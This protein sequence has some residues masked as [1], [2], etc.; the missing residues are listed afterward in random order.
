MEKT[1]DADRKRIAELKQAVREDLSSQCQR[2]AVWPAFL[3]DV[4]HYEAEQKKL[5]SDIVELQINIEVQQRQNG[6]L[7]LLI[8]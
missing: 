1:A 7:E 3:H 5:K 6:W 8:L 2:K 4:C